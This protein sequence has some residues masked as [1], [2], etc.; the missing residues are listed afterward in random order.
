MNLANIA[1]YRCRCEEDSVA[2]EYGRGMASAR[3]GKF[4]FDVGAGPTQRD[5]FGGTMTI[6]FHTP[7]LRPIRFGNEAGGKKKAC[8]GDQKGSSCRRHRV[9]RRAI[10][11]PY[12]NKS[13][14]R[15]CRLFLGD[16]ECRILNGECRRNFARLPTSSF[17][18]PCSVFDIP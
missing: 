8:R 16:L 10:I 13:G 9:L 15:S 2:P 18:I 1:F 11:C 7:P 5:I 4:P 17:D 3:N 14:D 6:R 12:V